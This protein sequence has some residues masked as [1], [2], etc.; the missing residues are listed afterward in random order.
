MKSNNDVT[1]S[2]PASNWEQ[3]MQDAIRQLF[4]NEMNRSVSEGSNASLGA[5]LR[6]IWRRKWLVMIPLIVIPIFAILHIFSEKPIYRAN[7]RLIIEPTNQ[8][9]VNFE[10]V[11]S[12]DRSRDYIQTQ[13]KML[14][15]YNVAAKVIDQLNADSL[16][17]IKSLS[18]DNPK[19]NAELSISFFDN[20]MDRVRSVFNGIEKDGSNVKVREGEGRKISH[21]NY[22]EFEIERHRKIVEL[23]NS[24]QIIPMRNTRLVNVIVNGYDRYM[25]TSQANKLAEVFVEQNLENKREASRTASEWLKKEV[26]NLKEELQRAEFALL[27][28]ID[29][30]GFASINENDVRQNRFKSVTGLDEMEE[31]V[32]AT[33]IE[34]VDL[35]NKM[36]ELGSLVKRIPNNPHLIFSDLDIPNLQ[37]LQRQYIETQEEIEALSRQYKGK[38]PRIKELYEKKETINRDVI[39]SIKDEVSRAKIKIDILLEKEKSLRDVMKKEREEALKINKDSIVYN[40]LK[41][42]IENKREL[43]E[44]MLRRLNETEVTKGLQT[45]NIT[46]AQKA[47]VPVEPLPSKKKEILF[48]S[49]VISLSIGIGLSIFIE[50]LNKRFNDPDE[51]EKYMHVPY[52]GSVYKVKKIRNQNDLVN[53][54]IPYT[55]ISNKYRELRTKIQFLSIH[56][57]IK[58]VLVTSAVQGEG[59]SATLVNLALSYSQLGKSILIVDADFRQPVLHT[60]L[61]LPNDIG[62]S[63]ILIGSCSWEQAV[64]DT[65]VENLKVIT[66]GSIP[67]N[68]LELLSMARMKG[69][70]HQFENAFD[71]VFFDGSCLLGV[72]DAAMLATEM[73]GVILVHDP[74]QVKIKTI[75]QAKKVLEDAYADIIGIVFSNF[76]DSFLSP[77]IARRLSRSRRKRIVS[78]VQKPLLHGKER[79]ILDSTNT[80]STASSTSRT[81]GTDSSLSIEIKNSGI[82]N[83]LEH[84]SIEEGFDFLVIDLELSNYSGNLVVFETRN[85]TIQPGEISRYGNALDIVYTDNIDSNDVK[86]DRVQYYPLNLDLSYLLKDREMINSNESKSG[87]IIYKVPCEFQNFTLLYNTSDIRISLPISI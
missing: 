51:V 87:K 77:R 83:N 32:R 10:E 17:L 72:L 64:Q 14:G 49:I 78:S 54:Q 70:C 80:L 40:A 46:I 45:N 74:D 20:I 36:E 11:V 57:P 3:E 75:L 48:G 9:I 67:P 65:V 29:T 15:S 68:P 86:N 6:I 62:L 33:K 22:S 50:N 42:D 30:Q 4:P 73:D 63:D 13:Y 39:L 85:V 25:I 58:L 8:K 5:Y 43:Y 35:Q 18:V 31:T 59:K 27:E 12:P 1:P 76:K 34:I 38:Y 81:I 26:E 19:T 41:R 79:Q 69:L 84:F 16:G 37:N 71:M 47:M 56:Q 21:H 28:F 7:A 44:R 82:V 66:S 52:L 2:R 60:I 61:D 24:T 53:T 23:L 55:Y